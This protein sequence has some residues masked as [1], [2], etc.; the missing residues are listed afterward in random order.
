[1]SESLHHSSGHRRRRKSK[2]R[3]IKHYLKKPWVFMSIIAVA[4]LAVVLTVGVV[5]QSGEETVADPGYTKN[6]DNGDY[7]IVLK[8]FDEPVSLVNKAASVCRTGSNSNSDVN[9]DLLPYN[10]D[11]ERLDQGLP[12]TISFAVNCGTESIRNLVVSVSKDADFNN[13]YDYQLDNHANSCS[14]YNLEPG[15]HYYYSVSC[16]LNNGKT[17]R[18]TGEFDTEQSTRQLKIDGAENLRDIGGLITNIGKIVKYG[19]VF[20][21]SELDG[22][23]DGRYAVKN[24]GIEEFIRVTGVKMDMDLRNPAD[25]SFKKDILGEDV[26][27]KY[28][29]A[30]MYGGVF[31]DKETIRSIFSD[32][33]D[34]KNYPVYIHCTYGRDRT[35]TICYLLEGLLGVT[36]EYRDYDYKLSA[37]LPYNQNYGLIDPIDVVLRLNYDGSST[38]KRIEKYL[39]SCGVTQ[40]EIDSIKST[41]VE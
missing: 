35:G 16:Q 29:S 6:G 5:I 2:W 38:E 10:R 15:V 22:A 27:H 7:R 12:V 24:D 20:R 19:M 21:G 39:L 34:P 40:S 9:L 37:L 28:Y 11:I 14:I 30:P 1:M 36:E 23:G 41:L 17:L 4:V 13:A 3:V 25:L 33:A 31:E 18:E 32:L 8:E 26:L